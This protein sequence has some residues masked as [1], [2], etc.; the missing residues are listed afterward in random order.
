MISDPV[1]TVYGYHII[2]VLAH[3]D[4]RVKPFTEVKDDIAKQWKQQHSN[5]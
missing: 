5:R 2:Q 3:E 1:K 4:A